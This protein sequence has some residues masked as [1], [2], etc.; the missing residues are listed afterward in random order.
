MTGVVFSIGLVQAPPPLLLLGGHCLV[1]FV[2]LGSN[3]MNMERFPAIFL[4]CVKIS[5]PFDWGMICEAL[6]IGWLDLCLL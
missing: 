1:N 6:G 5:L 2:A 3:E 4:L